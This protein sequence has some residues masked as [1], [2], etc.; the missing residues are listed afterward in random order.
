[1]LISIYFSLDFA[2]CHNQFVQGNGEPTMTTSAE[3]SVSEQLSNACVQNHHQQQPTFMLFIALHMQGACRLLLLHMNK[4][5][6]R[7]HTFW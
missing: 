5:D 3:W 2:W 1:M 4:E 7:K 6:T